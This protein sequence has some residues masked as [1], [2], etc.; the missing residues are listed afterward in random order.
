MNDCIRHKSAEDYLAN[1]RCGKKQSLAVGKAINVG[2]Q[3][4]PQKKEASCHDTGV[5]QNS[6]PVQYS[7]VDQQTHKTNRSCSANRDG[8]LTA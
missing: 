4:S 2:T 1:E 7:S 6:L 5:K 3:Q 8:M